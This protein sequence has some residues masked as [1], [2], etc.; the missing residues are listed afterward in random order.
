[1][2]LKKFILILTFFV[3]TNFTVLN[4]SFSE[5]LKISTFVPPK[6]KFNTMLTQWG[7]TLKE[8]SG[9]ELN[10]E[11]FPSGQLG[12]PPRQFDLV[13]NGVA[14]IAVVL[15]SMTPGR[16]PLSELAGLPFTNPKVENSS[17]FSS[18]RLTELAN[19]FL[20][21]EHKG[22]KI[23]MMAVTPP[24]KIHT[25]SFNP[26]DFENFEGKRIR[27][28][29]KIWKQIVEKLGAS[30]VPVPPA[31]TADAMSKGVVDGATFPYEATLPF[32]L[33][34]VSKFTLEPG[35]A[36]VTFAVVMSEKSYNRL[37]D[38][39]KALIDETTG[40]NQAE[41]FGKVWDKVEGVGRNYMEK[42]GVQII[43]MSDT[44]INSLSELL[45]SVTES[46]I[47]SVDDSGLP[48]TEFLK[49]FT[50]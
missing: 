20:L 36:S 8:K 50:E 16:F 2:Y 29:G 13:L 21:D 42:G 40:A 15:H 1:M 32:D 46:N 45:S 34:P 12:P 38:A 10:V 28:A 43:T 4:I 24:L 35:I 48:G 27:Y 23:L 39:H 47:K 7:E 5:T 30:P 33:A 41:A 22:T 9:G 11:I 3:V 25:N 44:Q 19:K 37:S 31:A 26:G 6:H 49:A 14:D 17:A 18:K